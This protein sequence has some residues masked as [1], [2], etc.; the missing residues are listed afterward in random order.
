MRRVSRKNS[1]VSRLSSLPSISR[2]E[3]QRKLVWSAL[4]RCSTNSYDCF[5]LTQRSCCCLD[6]DRGGGT[7]NW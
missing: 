4:A 6:A 3:S 7:S 2:P 1:T 5:P